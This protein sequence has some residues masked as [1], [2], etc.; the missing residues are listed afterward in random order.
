[1]FAFLAE[2]DEEED[3]EQA[4][5]VWVMGFRVKMLIDSFLDYYSN[6]VPWKC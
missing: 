3:D 6:L 2:V 4:L 5:F 1:M